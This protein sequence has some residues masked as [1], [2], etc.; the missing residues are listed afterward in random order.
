MRRRTVVPV[1]GGGQQSRGCFRMNM[2]VNRQRCTCAY[3]HTTQRCMCVCVC[4][5]RHGK[6]DLFGNKWSGHDY[7]SGQQPVT[8]TSNAR[9]CID[10]MQKYPVTERAGRAQC[11]FSSLSLLCI[12]CVQHVTLPL[13][14]SVPVLSGPAVPLYDSCMRR[15]AALR[16]SW[17]PFSEQVRMILATS[18]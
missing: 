12:V 10:T 18:P 17:S 16:F 11:L 9:V 4:V 14:R 5:C 2:T 3:G 8:R 6:H 15:Q 13:R 7:Q 1:V